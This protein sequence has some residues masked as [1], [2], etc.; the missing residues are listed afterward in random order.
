MTKTKS[1]NWAGITPSYSAGWSCARQDSGLLEDQQAEKAQ[2][3]ALAPQ[4]ASCTPG[5]AAG[6]QPADRGISPLGAC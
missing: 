2:H 1:C 6:A 5:C 4:V 3:G